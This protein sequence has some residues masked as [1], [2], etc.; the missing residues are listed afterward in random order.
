MESS[1]RNYLLPQNDNFINWLGHNQLLLCPKK[2]LVKRVTNIDPPLH[3]MDNMGS[4]WPSQ[5]LY[6]FPGYVTRMTKNLMAMY[7]WICFYR[8]VGRAPGTTRPPRGVT[9]LL[10][11]EDDENHKNHNS[12][13][14]FH[15]RHCC[16]TSLRL[17]WTNRLSSYSGSVK[18]ENK[19]PSN[20]KKTQIP[21]NTPACT[22]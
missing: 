21:K 8:Q 18:P 5:I 17:G 6:V 7:Q 2:H 9:E 22:V 14:Y 12:L 19:P 15:A 10:E 20:H 3:F 4:I 16:Y 11:D 1:K 13:H